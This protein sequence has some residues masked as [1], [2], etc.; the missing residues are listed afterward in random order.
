MLRII[1]TSSLLFSIISELFPETLILS[2][3]EIKTLF[4]SSMHY[5][6]EHQYLQLHEP[7]F[8]SKYDCIGN[9]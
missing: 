3:E 8:Q 1:L 9:T 2:S 7:I 4:T 5:Q 6:T